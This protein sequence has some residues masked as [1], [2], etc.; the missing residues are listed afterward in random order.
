MRPRLTL[1][2]KSLQNSLNFLPLF[3]GEPGYHVVT[4]TADIHALE[5]DTHV[6][7]VDWTPC[8]GVGSSGFLLTR[9]FNDVNDCLLTTFTIQLDGV[10]GSDTTFANVSLDSVS[11]L[12]NS[13]VM[14]H[15][16]HVGSELIHDFLTGPTELFNQATPGIGSLNRGE[17]TTLVLLHHN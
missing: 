12:E 9:F 2:I 3:I 17:L 1:C 13:H 8:V 7:T 6:T 16:G 14:C 11:E 4:L 5:Q 10:V 15:S